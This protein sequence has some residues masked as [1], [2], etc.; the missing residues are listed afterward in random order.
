MG[1]GLK[2]TWG[3]SFIPAVWR[4]EKDVKSCADRFA[5]SNRT[6]KYIQLNILV[7]IAVQR[8]IPHRDL[9]L[10]L[11][12][13][14]GRSARKTCRRSGCS[15]SKP[16]L[17]KKRLGPLLFQLAADF[18]NVR[19]HGPRKAYQGRYDGR[20]KVKA[21]FKNGVVRIEM[22][23]TENSKTRKIAVQGL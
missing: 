1:G 20:M 10:A 4:H 7:R 21:D 5:G 23:K 8:E 6:N 22:P 12:P 9:R 16:G 3:R 17:S 2:P 13:L 11:L 15:F 14:G 19:L 18:V